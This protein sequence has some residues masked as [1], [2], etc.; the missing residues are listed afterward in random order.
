MCR[1]THRAEGEGGGWKRD[2]VSLVAPRNGSRG[3]VMICQKTAK[4]AG[5]LES[6]GR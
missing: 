6:F 2:Y 3:F 4:K 1:S 5:R